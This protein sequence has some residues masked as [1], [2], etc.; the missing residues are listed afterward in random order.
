MKSDPQQEDAMSSKSKSATV[1]SA[2]RTRAGKPPGRPA[3]APELW[4]QT[5]QTPE[6]RDD[7]IDCQRIVR[8]EGSRS[9]PLY[10]DDY[11]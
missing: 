8:G 2:A 11:N 7:T 4:E 5:A 10:Y 3:W 6:E 9:L 1:R